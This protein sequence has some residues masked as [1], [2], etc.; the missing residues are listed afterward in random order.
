[1][2]RKFTNDDLASLCEERGFIFVER[3]PGVQRI[4]CKDKEGYMYNV[5]YTNL[6]KAVPQ[7]Y[8]KDNPYAIDNI[9]RYLK[10]NDINL[11]VIDG[12]EYNGRHKPM[13]FKTY[14]EKYNRTR[15]STKLFQSVLNGTYDN[16]FRTHQDFVDE[17]KL[18][19][20]HIT[21]VGEFKNMATHVKCKCNICSTVWDADPQCLL[22]GR[23][24]YLGCPKC[25]LQR[26]ADELRKS[27]DQFVQEI[28]NM[29][30]YYTVVGE[31]VSAVTP[32]EMRCD[33]HSIDFLSTPHKILAGS[34]GCKQCEL[35]KIHKKGILPHDQ[36]IE[37]QKTIN[38]NVEFL[39]AYDGGY[40]YITA[41]CKICGTVW[42]ALARIFLIGG[43]H[44]PSCVNRSHGEVAI[45]KWLDDHD[46]EYE[47]TKT[48]E[49]LVGLGGRLL[50]Y[51]FYLPLYNCLIEFQGIQHNEPVEMFGGE[52]QL[53]KQL[54]HD[55]RK[56]QYASVNNIHLIE[57]WYD[58][59][60]DVDAILDSCL[61]KIKMVS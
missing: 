57:I 56:R 9:K 51:D 18:I 32:I 52:E 27:H 12:E 7:R 60:D 24:E 58:E 19:Y 34:T 26:R 43:N 5:N 44:C 59:I 61:S 35:E 23:D 45:S 36:F 54:E 55:E 47:T 14:D 50:S 42:D 39:T 28:N 8:G 1:M 40:S 2:G 4:I 29:Y 46:I 30:P 16:N 10:I 48:Y 20:P 17:M 6:R 15:Y 41:K 13:R 11:E 33:K 22:Y 49:G 31:Y 53:A 3:A 25:D 37:K 38:P 21:V